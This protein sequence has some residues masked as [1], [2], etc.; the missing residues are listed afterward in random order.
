MEDNIIKNKRIMIVD[1]N[2]ENLRL[3]TSILKKQGYKVFPVRDE[4]TALDFACLKMPDLILLDI[5]MPKISGYEVCEQLNA[6]KRTREIPIIFVTAMDKIEDKVKAFSLGGVDYIIKPFQEEEVLARV[7]VH[8]IIKALQQQ[9][10]QQNKL[11]LEQ[12]RRF[13]VL[14]K[15]AFEGM[16]IY[17]SEQIIEVNSRI[18]NMT[19][20]HRD[21]IT[22]QSLLQLISPA[23][24]V[25]ANKFMS[26]WD[27]N[28]FQVEIL[29]RD[30]SDIPVEIRCRKMPYQGRDVRILALRDMGYLQ[31]LKR[32]N[33]N[34]KS[35]LKDRY[36]FGLLVGKSCV[37]QKVYT[38]IAKASAF[39]FNTFIT[40]ETGTG[41]ELTAR[42]IHGK[43]LR[44][45]YSFVAVNC[46]AIPENLFE[47]EFFGYCRGAFSGADKDKPGFFDQAHKGILFLDEVTELRVDQQAK[48]L[49]V[50]QDG[51]YYPVG[52]TAGKK[53][54]VM[55]IAASNRKPGEKVLEGEMR[56]DFYYRINVL[57]IHLPPLRERPEDIPL[58][59][60]HFLTL[61]AAGTH[62]GQI[63]PELLR[64]FYSYEWPGNIREL[65]N[66]LQRHIA[67]SLPDNIFA[68]LQVPEEK[69]SKGL[70]EAVE[71]LEKK[72][73]LN[74][75]E[76]HGW[77]RERSASMLKIPRRTL[78][79]KMLKYNLKP[80]E[81]I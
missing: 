29:H 20:Y 68:G 27:D 24:H 77:H 65:M 6:N 73:I 52:D 69:D 56:E 40:G 76:Q 79:R 12:N 37:M 38:Q 13:Q 75:L 61:Y 15:A 44:K 35:D 63:S 50:I 49:R 81:D 51:E 59:I 33:L 21:E 78:H 9:I 48:L 80:C 46:S 70:F 43:S 41:K 64:Y 7:R 66:M 47:S 25:T 2:P 1:D 22:G 55:I 28:T 16:I 30:G 11:L 32:E 58:L 8:L 60:E 14:E 5:M 36:R 62:S 45:D 53:V 4:N 71:E 18:E 42:T 74:A 72:L 26:A 39:G 31:R 17:D 54:D 23:F 34:L 19:G 57:E 67:G 3:L 10:L